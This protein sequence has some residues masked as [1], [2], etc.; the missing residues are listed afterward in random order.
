MTVPE[1]EQRLQEFSIRLE[2]TSGA[3]FD[4]FSERCSFCQCLT[5]QNG[6]LKD[7][8]NLPPCLS[9]HVQNKMNLNTVGHHVCQLRNIGRVED[10]DFVN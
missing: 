8:L 9:E 10:A 3:G 1:S 5:I 7:F 4:C 2:C 6:F